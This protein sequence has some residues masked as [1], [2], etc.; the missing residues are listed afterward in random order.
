MGLL[1]LVVITEGRPFSI[2]AENLS[3]FISALGCG[4]TSPLNKASTANGTDGN[5]VRVGV[6][7]IAGVAVRI[8]LVGLLSGVSSGAR[9][10][11]DS[12]SGCRV[13]V[14]KKGMDGRLNLGSCMRIISRT[15]A[16]TKAPNTEKAFCARMV[17]CWR[18]M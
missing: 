2:C 5:C 13:W 9:V 8:K 14:L 1:K 16:A 15:P 17:F 11:V 12:E 4:V 3:S 10:C 6:G 7:E 18:V